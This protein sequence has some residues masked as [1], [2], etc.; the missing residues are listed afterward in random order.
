[1]SSRPAWTFYTVRL[2]LKNKQDSLP[3]PLGMGLKR[4]MMDDSLSA[5]IPV[6]DLC[7]HCAQLCSHWLLSKPLSSA[8][9]LSPP[10]CHL[11][12]TVGTHT[13]HVLCLPSLSSPLLQPC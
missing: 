1:M 6:K 9:S 2:C 3:I 5:E 11:A 8:S 4:E 7:E 12:E 10:V 13:L